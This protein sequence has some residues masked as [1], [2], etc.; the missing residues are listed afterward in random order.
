MLCYIILK[1]TFVSYVFRCLLV[2][3]VVCSYKTS[4]V[5]SN[6]QLVSD[7][8]KTSKSRKHI[9]RLVCLQVERTSAKPESEDWFEKGED[10]RRCKDWYSILR[11]DAEDI[12][13]NSKIKSSGRR[14]SSHSSE[15]C[16]DF[17]FMSKIFLQVARTSLDGSRSSGIFV[18]HWPSENHSGYLLCSQSRYPY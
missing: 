14:A 13:A 16:K 17:S 10:P 3:L 7:K 15:D 2:T 6:I 1:K 9:G 12:D 18:E 11:E 5:E 4:C 8:K